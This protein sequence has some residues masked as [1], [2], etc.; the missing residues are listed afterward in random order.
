[1]LLGNE[2]VDLRLPE[3]A[4]PPEADVSLGEGSCVCE[5]FQE[6]TRPL[7][8]APNA[9]LLAADRSFISEDVQGMVRTG[10]SCS[11]FCSSRNAFCVRPKLRLLFSDG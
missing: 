10:Q 8:L 3:E 1:M 6:A 4:L 7:L 2:Q 11:A 5:A 9:E